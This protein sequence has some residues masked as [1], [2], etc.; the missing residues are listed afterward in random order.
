MVARRSPPWFGFFFFW[1]FVLS[2]GPRPVYELWSLY[3]WNT[4]SSSIYESEPLGCG[5]RS[6]PGQ[7]R[8]AKSRVDDLW[9]LTEKLICFIPSRVLYEERR[10][11]STSLEQF[12]PALERVQ[13]QKSNC[14]L[15]LFIKYRPVANIIIVFNFFFELNVF[16]ST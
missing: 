6:L 3:L 16:P 12:P 5:V 4:S 10:P 8:H 13:Q 9:L 14:I 1:H 7:S 2:R 11:T 15:I